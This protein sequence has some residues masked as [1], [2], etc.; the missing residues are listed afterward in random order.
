MRQK[1]S[2]LIVSQSFFPVIGGVSSFLIGLTSGL[3][4]RGY[5]INLLHFKMSDSD[6]FK[7]IYPQVRQHEVDAASCFSAATMERYARFKEDIYRKLHGLDPL[8]IG[9]IQEIDGYEAFKEVTGVFCLRA[10]EIMREDQ[11]DILNVHDYQLFP[12][13][14]VAAGSVKTVLNIHTPILPSYPRDTIQF[15]RQLA[16]KVNRT[17]V[18]IPDYQSA[19]LDGD[20]EGRLHVTCLPPFIDHSLQRRLFETSLCLNA[21]PQFPFIIVSIQRF[22]AKSGHKQLIEGFSRFIVDHPD[23]L[24]VLVGGP[25]FTDSFSDVRQ[26]YYQE[27]RELAELLGIADRVFFAGPVP[28]HCIGPIYERADVF[29]MLSRNECF[30]LALTEAMLRRV[31]AVVTGVG[32]LGYQI[33]NGVDGIVVRV[34]DSAAVATALKVLRE[35]PKLR[36][37]FAESAYQRYRDLF[38][39]A[40]IMRK[41]HALYQ[42]L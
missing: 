20:T 30:G 16:S 21:L 33:R 10:A 39:P 4:A 40:S 24:L 18:S 25:S 36:K 22:D 1:Q 26:R 19:L 35:A 38:Q 29:C 32:G 12:V 28:Y 3:A 17:V 8:G 2:I 27:A 23:A 6:Q 15:L 5:R 37:H 14:D 41:Y 42:S 9:D 11:I 34:D 31:P 7:N 13:L